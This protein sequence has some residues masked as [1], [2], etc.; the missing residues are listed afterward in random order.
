VKTK[1]TA[2]IRERVVLRDTQVCRYCLAGWQLEIHHRQGRGGDNPNRLSNLLTLC[3][4]C[5][6][7]VTEHPEMAY[8]LGL[9]VKRVGLDQP[10]EVPFR[11]STGRMWCLDDEG[12]LFRL[13][14]GG[15]AA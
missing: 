2:E 10:D 15:R 13:P 1:L 9:S 12:N 5:H 11:D 6:K 7:W 4:S 8:Q 14:I 3:S